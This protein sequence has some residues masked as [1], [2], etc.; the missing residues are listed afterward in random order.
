MAKMARKAQQ[1]RSAM[2]K[3]TAAGRSKSGLTAILLNGLNDIEE[4]EFDPSLGERCDLNEIAREV[5]DAFQDAKKAL[6]K[7]LAESM[8]VDSL[9]DLLS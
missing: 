3:V 1:T 5:K 2:K 6:E 4:I 8:D 9:R 7:V